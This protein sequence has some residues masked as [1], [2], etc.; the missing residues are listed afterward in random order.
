MNKYILNY[1]SCNNNESMDRC[2]WEISLSSESRDSNSNFNSRKGIPRFLVCSFAFSVQASWR[3]F[4]PVCYKTV[5]VN[6]Y[7]IDTLDWRSVFGVW[8]SPVSNTNMT[9]TYVITF[10]YFHFFR[11]LIVFMCLCQYFIVFNLYLLVSPLILILV[12]LK[13]W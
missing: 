6:L 12:N 11:L 4:F 3:I 8:H 7:S 2:I 13:N 10:N 1:K 5:P 9:L